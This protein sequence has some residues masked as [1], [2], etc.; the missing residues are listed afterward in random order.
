MK[1]GETNKSMLLSAGKKGTAENVTQQSAQPLM[2]TGAQQEAAGKPDEPLT[3][4][5]AANSQGKFGGSFSESLNLAFGANAGLGIAGGVV[6][7]AVVAYIAYEMLYK[8]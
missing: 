5:A 2:T 7:V 3:A 6:G 4:D 8:K 1:P